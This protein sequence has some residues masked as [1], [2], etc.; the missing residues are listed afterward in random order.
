MACAEVCAPCLPSVTLSGSVRVLF[1]ASLAVGVAHMAAEDDRCSVPE[2]S[3]PFGP[4]LSPSDARGVG[5]SLLAIAS[6]TPA[7]FPFTPFAL[8]SSWRARHVSGSSASLLTVAS[9]V[10]HIRI[11]SVSVTPGRLV[12][13]VDALALL[14]ASAA[15]GVGQ[16]CAAP[17]NVGLPRSKVPLALSESADIG[18]GHPE[19]EDSLAP[20]RGACV[21]SSRD[22][23]LNAVIH[24]RHSFDDSLKPQGGVSTHVLAKDCARTDLTNDAKNVGDHVSRVVSSESLAGARVADARVAANDEIHKSTPSS[25][26]EGGQVAPDRRLIQAAFFHTRD[27]DAGGICLPFDVAHD[28]RREA[29]SSESSLDAE[30]E[31]SDAG[32]E[33]EDVNGTYS[34]T[35]NSGGA[36]TRTYP[37]VLPR[38]P[39]HPCVPIAHR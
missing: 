7:P 29:C 2:L 8:S 6:G 13:F 10:G 18:V 19:P 37:D 15:T 25:T 22:E 4:P 21:R 26:I 36:R 34:H 39:K 1:A 3:R 5:H 9:G 16:P 27:Q 17:D 20:V 32:R 12:P 38:V 31:P 14:S 11:A 24:A 33:G 30:I 28:A 23:R 35:N